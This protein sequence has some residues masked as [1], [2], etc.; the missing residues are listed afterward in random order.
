MKIKHICHKTFI[1]YQENPNAN[2]TGPPTK[3]PTMSE[4]TILQVC[5]S[6][7]LLSAE[8]KGMRKGSLQ[9]GRLKMQ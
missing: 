1:S 5:P 7:S 2:S 6:L 4:I 3:G 9:K 8:L